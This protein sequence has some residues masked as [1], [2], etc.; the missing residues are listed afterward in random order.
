MVPNL[1]ISGV[2][3]V[4]VSTKSH[5]NLPFTSTSCAITPQPRSSNHSPSNKTSSSHEGWV[6]GK[7]AST[8]LISTPSPHRFSTI[9]T[10]VCFRLY[11]TNFTASKVC[12][13]CFSGVW[14]LSLPKI[15]SGSFK[16]D[17]NTSQSLICTKQKMKYNLHELQILWPHVTVWPM[18]IPAIITILHEQYLIFLKKQNFKIISYIILSIYVPASVLS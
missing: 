7:Y 9:P 1:G 16:M 18:K 8:H 2:N 6:K 3:G 15:S 17:K 5:F 10:R 11:S 14:F 4:S 13:A 12:M